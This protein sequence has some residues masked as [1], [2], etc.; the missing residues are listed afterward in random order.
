METAG[1]EE[2]MKRLVIVTIL[3]LWVCGCGAREPATPGVQF[4][5]FY[6]DWCGPCN[7]QKPIVDRLEKQFASVRFRHVDVDREAKLAQ[8]YGV[9]SIPC[10][11]IVVD[12][13]EK[14]RF[15]GL[16]DYKTLAEAL[17]KYQSKAAPPTP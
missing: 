10:M 14:Q 3:C 12:G 1:T 9:R 2:K 13:R 7:T 15:I 5:K 4:L 17:G 8:K 6:A 11:V 16:Q